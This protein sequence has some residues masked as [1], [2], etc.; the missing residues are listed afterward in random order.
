VTRP[1]VGL[2]GH[3]DNYDLQITMSESS[4]RGYSGRNVPPT[5]MSLRRRVDAEPAG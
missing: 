2:V 4:S 5:A 1:A 3:L